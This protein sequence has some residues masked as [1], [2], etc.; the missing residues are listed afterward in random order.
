MTPAPTSI[1]WTWPH[2]AISGK[3]V[4]AS[5]L[6]PASSSE[7]DPRSDSSRYTKQRP[8]CKRGLLRPWHCI[9]G[10]HT[11]KAE[12]RSQG[13][14][15]PSWSFSRSTLEHS[16]WPVAAKVP[17]WRP[18]LELLT[19]LS[20][21]AKSPGEGSARKSLV[22]TASAEPQGATDQESPSLALPAPEACLC[23]SRF[24]G[25]WL[26]RQGGDS[27]NVSSL[28]IQQPVPALRRAGST[29]QRRDDSRATSIIPIDVTQL[30][31]LTNI[32]WTGG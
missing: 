31:V 8:Q 32:P 16:G 1:Q 17:S 4:G 20:Y 29:E 25:H 6:R 10:A 22:E 9:K 23:L 26:L 7:Q 15:L 28:G 24:A 14:V 5:L 19:H 3:V 27:G 21:G 2:L 13:W 11:R 18:G 30:E 12:A